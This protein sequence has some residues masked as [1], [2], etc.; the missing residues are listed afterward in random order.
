MALEKRFEDDFTEPTSDTNLDSHTP[1]GSGSGFGVSWSKNAGPAA[2]HAQC[3]ASD[4]TLAH[5]YHTGAST[6]TFYTAE[7]SG[8]WEP[9]QKAEATKPQSGN[10]NIRLAVRLSSGDDGYTWHW[11][12]G[13]STWRLNSVTNGTDS[14]IGSDTQANPGT[15]LQD[16]EADGNTITGRRTGSADVS[17]SN[18][19]HTTGKPG[20]VTQKSL[21]SAGADG[22]KAYDEAVAAAGHPAIRRL[23]GVP[24]ARDVRGA[25][26]MRTF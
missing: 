26:N 20:V 22:Y 6:L 2:S 25:G 11:G 13:D 16:I 8:T 5:P 23:G 21:A 10:S 18:S 24:Y 1:T 19:D 15:L 4:D 7:I 12:S 9:H 14:L 3:I 17:T